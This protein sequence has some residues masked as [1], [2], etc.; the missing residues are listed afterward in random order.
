MHSQNQCATIKWQATLNYFVKINFDGSVKTNY[1]ICGFML[2]DAN[3]RLV[4]AAYNRIGRSSVPIAEVVALRDGLLKAKEK[5]LTN[6]K[7]EGDSKLM[8]DAVNDRFEPPWRLIKLVDDI[9]TLA[10]SLDSIIFTHVFT[11]ANFVVDVI[12]N[13][14]HACDSPLYWN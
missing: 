8:I 3:G 11:E 1:A 4:F 9:R 12:T 5:R 13:L 10:T 2:R 14:G 6:V 7:V